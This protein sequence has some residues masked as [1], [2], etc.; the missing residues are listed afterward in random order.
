MYPLKTL[1]LALLLGWSAPALALLPSNATAEAANSESSLEKR[2]DIKMRDQQGAAVLNQMLSDDAFWQDASRWDYDTSKNLY[3]KIMLKPVKGGYVPMISGE[4]DTD[5]SQD[6]VA[7]TVFTKMTKLP[8]YM[9]GAEAVKTLGSG[10]D[11]D[12][13]ADYV[14]SYYVLNMTLFYVVYPQRMYRKYDA[15]SDR[16][17]LWF[18]KLTPEFVDTGT[19]QTYQTKIDAVNEK[20]PGGWPFSAMVE[21]AQVY[22]MYIVGDGRAHE[23]RVTFVSKLDFGED[24]GMMAKMG[25]KM[26]PILKAGLQSGFSASVNIA[27]GEQKRRA[28]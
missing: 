2:A 4:G 19:W 11:S 21:V 24:A 26:K 20:V 13:G 12:I 3:D 6:V 18:E 9:D 7:D 23:S 25:S 28:G 1:T 5:L 27:K 14:D 16:T 10:Y 8:L 22:G 15:G 17:L